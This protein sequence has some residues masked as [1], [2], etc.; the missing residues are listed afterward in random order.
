MKILISG[1]GTGGHIY[2]AIAIANKIKE[3]MHDVEILFV[4]T[5]RGLENQLVPKAG[6]S[7]KTI[8]VSGYKRKLSFELQKSIKYLFIGLK[9]SL[10]ISKTFQPDLVIG[11]GGYVC[12]PVVFIASMLNIKTAIH[13]Q[14]VIPGITNKILGMYVDKVFISFEESQK[15]FSH[16]EKLIVTGNPVRQEFL[17]LDKNSCRENWEF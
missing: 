4:G 15:Y 17:N 12:G 11:T 10:Q 2:P 3:N 9:D 14:N 7:L 6:Y 1:G 13:E 5:H 16:K 8:T